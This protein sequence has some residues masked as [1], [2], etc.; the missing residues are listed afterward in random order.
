MPRHTFPYVELPLPPS[1]PFPNG[2]TVCRPLAIA[3]LSATNGKTV[4]CVVWLDSGADSCV[5]PVSFAIALGL[6]PLTMKQQLTGGVGN[7]GNV[8]YYENLTIEVGQFAS[9]NG[10]Q[11]FQTLIS[12]VAYVGFTVGLEAQGIGLLGQAG[13]FENYSV[14]FDHKGRQFHID[15]V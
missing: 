8:T 1:D 6:D 15:Q 11:T 13:F 9:V 7:S 3:R 14:T 10:I 5:F 4:T 12:F 2:T